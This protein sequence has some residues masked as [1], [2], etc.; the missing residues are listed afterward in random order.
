MKLEAN[1]D[2]YSM[3]LVGMVLRVSVEVGGYNI[4]LCLVDPERMAALKRPPAKHGVPCYAAH[5][6]N[7]STGSQLQVDPIPDTDGLLRVRYLPPA[8]EA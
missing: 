6:S 2:T 8:C 7:T 3:P 5:I 4:P 1:K